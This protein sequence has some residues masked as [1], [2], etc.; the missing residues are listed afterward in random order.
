MNEFFNQAADVG[1]DVAIVFAGLGIFLFGIKT[2]GDSLKV[3]AGAKMKSIID[4]ST[5]N[6]FNGV[7][8][9]A[10]VTGLLQSSSGTTALTISL[11]RAGLMNLR[12]AIGII[13]GANI[14]TTM[15]AILIGFKLSKYSPYILIV[16]AIMLMFSKRSKMHHISMVV[17]SFGAL[18]YGLDVMGGGLKVL[19]K[20]DLFYDFSVELSSNSFMGIG[21]GILMTVLI[22]SSSAT[23]G[24]L[25]SL[26]SDNLINLKG[27][28]PI[29]FGDN[30]GTTITGI[31]A[32][33]GGSIASKRAAAA[34][35]T[36]NIIGA[37]IFISILPFFYEFVVLVSE[38]FSLNNDMQIAFA[39]ATFNIS[40]TLLLLPF[41][42]QIEW[43]VTKLFKEDSDE[44]ITRI[45][46]D[47]KL[48][49]H[50]PQDAVTAAYSSSVEMANICK[51]LSVHTRKYVIDRQ[52]KSRE[53]L[54]VYEDIIN[55]YNLQISSY[56]T[57]IGES[58]LDEHYNMLQTALIYST[59]D[60]ERV[61][62]HFINL[63]K[64]FD[65]LFASKEKLTQYAIDD[66]NAMFDNVE[67]LL[68]NTIELLNEYDYSLV[69]EIAKLEDNLD[70]LNDSAKDGFVDRYKNGMLSGQIVTTLY[71]DML[72]EVER[73]GD[74]CENIALRLA[75]IY[76]E[77]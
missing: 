43:F 17:V 76:S 49:M 15:T 53:K 73:I 39:H 18:F 13:M 23:I 32:A 71:I 41:I 63:A 27:A 4:K 12:Q 10:F 28:L 44:D 47:E 8:V 21:L 52:M 54:D 7:L 50:S 61:G 77:E 1:F 19:A 25:Q 26:Y 59:K 48:I 2:M 57:K 35:V 51:K 56:L 30:I 65:E 14:G 45:V 58:E 74:H 37:I 11:V 67:C 20:M 34:H 9:G 72:S 6:S 68:D 22:Q 33:I 62:D 55:D 24:I 16:G 29:L 40:T 70:M 66:L 46:L 38:K 42:N 5:T 3:V 60:L 64:E 69:A 36:F 75:K 31:L